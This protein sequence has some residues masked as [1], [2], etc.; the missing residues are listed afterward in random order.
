MLGASKDMPI[1]QF[2]D[3]SDLILNGNLVPIPSVS[4][5]PVGQ[6]IAVLKGAGF[7]AQVA[8]GANSNLAPGLVVYTSPSGAAVRGTTIGLFLS[9][10]SGQK[11]PPPT[12]SPSKT[13]KPRG[14][15]GFPTTFPTPTKP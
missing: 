7:N 12:P 4:G 14:P 5:M 6:A 3:P 9:T 1:R 2:D 13:K 11:P 10:G 8:G 15:S